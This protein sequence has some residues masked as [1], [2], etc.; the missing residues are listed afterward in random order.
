M[1][2]HLQINNN[3]ITITFN[4]EAACWQTTLT[5]D[6]SVIDIEIDLKFHREPQ[7]D[8]GHFTRFVQFIGKPGFIG[9]LVSRSM[10]LVTESGKAF[11]SQGAGDSKDW[12]M[13][14]SESIYYKGKPV[15]GISSDGLSYALIFNYVLEKEG[16]RDGDSYGLYLVEME[17]FHITGVRRYQC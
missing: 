8:W 16:F 10:P 12:K 7:V 13:V 5:I 9:G 17:D 6:T 3:K 14:F 4:E 1:Q 2:Q 11:L 15:D